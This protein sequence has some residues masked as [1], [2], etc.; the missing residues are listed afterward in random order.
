MVKLSLFVKYVNL[1]KDILPD[2]AQK[3]GGLGFLRTKIIQPECRLDYLNYF[4]LTVKS[5]VS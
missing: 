4:T 5:S 1:S 2:L 3:H